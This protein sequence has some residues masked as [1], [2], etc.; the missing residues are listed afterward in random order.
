[1]KNINYAVVPGT[2]YRQL[3][4]SFIDS[5]S[6][7]EQNSFLNLIPFEGDQIFHT[8]YSITDVNF[9]TELEKVQAFDVIKKRNIRRFSFDIG[10]CYTKTDVIDSKY[11]GVGD[12]LSQN[13]IIDLCEKKLDWFM[14]RVPSSCE[15]AV[16]N[17][18]FYP[19]ESGAYEEGVCEPEFYNQICK[20][21]GISLVLDLGHALVSAWNLK[22]NSREFLKQFD[23]DLISEIQL[24]KMG[25]SENQEAYDA[26]QRPDQ[27]EF[28]LVAEMLGEN[29]R[30]RDIVVEY[31][32]DPELLIE[33]YASLKAYFDAKN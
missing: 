16:E 17:L 21:F 27:V 11:V 3:P 24:C 30:Q 1:M 31:W 10:P 6:T 12:K 9:Q 32:K 15:V 33:C 14:R 2:L 23:L 28:Q 8:G 7:I 4:Q 19:T 22:V 26:H 13:E 29:R 5:F 20:T 25:V 18:N